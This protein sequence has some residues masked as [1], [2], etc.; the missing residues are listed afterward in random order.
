MKILK[1]IAIGLISLVVLLWA[2]LTAWAYWPTEP[3]VPIASLATT[4]DRFV[5]VN[6]VRLRYREWGSATDD[7]PS[8]LLIHGLIITTVRKHRC[9]LKQPKKS[10]YVG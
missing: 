4:D 7:R 3:E 6:G 2:G 1:R 10:A 8:L 9:S 5:E